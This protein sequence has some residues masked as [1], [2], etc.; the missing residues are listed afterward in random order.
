MPRVYWGY[1][2]SQWHVDP[3]RRRESCRMSDDR[4][5]ASSSRNTLFIGGVL[6]RTIGLDIVFQGWVIRLWALYS[7]HVVLN[8]MIW[9]SCSSC[10][11]FCVSHVLHV[12]SRFSIQFFHVFYVGGVTLGKRHRVQRGPSRCTHTYTYIHSYAHTYPIL[13]CSIV[14][15][16]F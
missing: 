14:C 10:L 6:L 9:I 13:V 8:S 5:H 11:G 4:V 3:A 15:T 7:S 12:L 2:K 16:L 1:A